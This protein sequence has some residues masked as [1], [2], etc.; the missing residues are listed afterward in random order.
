MASGSTRT[1]GFAFDVWVYQKVL[2]LTEPG[3]AG[4]APQDALL[5]LLAQIK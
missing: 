4:C 3:P 1:A 5:Y 2:N